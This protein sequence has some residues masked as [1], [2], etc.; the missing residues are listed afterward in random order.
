MGGSA[1]YHLPHAQ[2][3]SNASSALVA[4]TKELDETYRAVASRLPENPAVRFEGENDLVVSSLD[5]LEEPASLLALRNA[6]NE[7]LPR[8]DIEEVLLEIAAR[9]GYTDAFTHL[10]ERS[11]RAAELPISLCAVLLAEASN[12]GFEPLVRADIA[13][14][15]RS[16]LSWVDQNYIR[17]DTL[18]AANAILVAAQNRSA[19]AHQ[20]VVATWRQPTGCVSSCPCALCMRPPIRSI[21]VGN[22]A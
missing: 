2:L 1:S 7:R 13:A 9:T 16:R 4:I 10:T 19:L 11:A 12:T 21:S 6:V 22:A 3:V 20:W 8:V 17:N 14:L 18:V 15:K 5:K